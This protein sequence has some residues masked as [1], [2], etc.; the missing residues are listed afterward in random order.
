MSFVLITNIDLQFRAE[1]LVRA[2]SFACQDEAGIASWELRQAPYEH[3]KFYDPVSL[4]TAWSSHA[5][6]LMRRE[7]LDLVGG[8]EE[9]IFMYGEDVELSYRFRAA[10]YCLRY[11]PSA[12]VDHYTY[13]EP[14]EVKLLQYQG[15]TLANAY[16]RLRYG[17]WSDVLRI[18]SLYSR[19]AAGNAGVENNLQV[20]RKN[21]RFD[22]R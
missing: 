9:K 18:F 3:P 17:S 12:V 10:G 16:I 13:Q 21:I 20:V 1:S 14:G 5:C 22:T 8:Y 4:Q 6:I 15:S 11:L 19:L 2:V 7:V